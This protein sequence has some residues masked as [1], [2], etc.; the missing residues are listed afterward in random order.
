MEKTPA[1]RRFRNLML[2]LIALLVVGY[3]AYKAQ[4][5]AIAFSLWDGQIIEDPQGLSAK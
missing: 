1:D 5:I 3:G 2:A 4:V